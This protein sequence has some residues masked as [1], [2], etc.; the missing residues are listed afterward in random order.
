MTLVLV[1]AGYFVSGGLPRQSVFSLPQQ[2]LDALQ[3]SSNAIH[4]RVFFTLLGLDTVQSWLATTESIAGIVIEGACVAMLIQRFFGRCVRFPCSVSISIQ[5]RNSTAFQMAC[6]LRDTNSH[7][8]SRRVLD[9]AG[10]SAAA[11]AANVDRDAFHARS[12][13]EPFFC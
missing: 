8:Y 1:A 3:V 2:V 9:R 12:W 5:A 4:G 7:R 11:G 13:C 6:R 10:R